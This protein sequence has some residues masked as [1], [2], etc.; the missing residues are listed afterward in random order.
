MA[1]A[2]EHLDDAKHD[3][4]DGALDTALA[5]YAAVEP[6]AGLQDRILANLRAERAQ[7]P[8]R[9]WWRGGLAGAL[10]AVVVVAV[11][12][13]L[14]SGRSTQPVVAKHTPVTTQ[15]PR[16]P[17]RLV[18]NGEPN[19]IRP[20][21]H[22]PIRTLARPYQP[23]VVATAPPKLDQFPSPQP[24]SEQEQILESYVTN[25]PEHAALIARARAKELRLDAAEEMGT[26]ETGSEKAPQQ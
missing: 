25:Y 6:R 12:L 5:K 10:A 14:R 4:L 20:P 19:L 22:Q 17:E 3:D 8:D 13:A 7:V 15:S 2:Y 11:T 1:E 23:K 18:A 26:G 16:E 24:L 9:S 21:D